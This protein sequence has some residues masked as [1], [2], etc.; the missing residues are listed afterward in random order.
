MR[1][2]RDLIAGRRTVTGR[3]VWWGVFGFFAAVFAANG[4]M[5]WLA[6]STFSGVETEDAYQ[7]GR[8]FNRAIEATRQQRALGWQVSITQEPLATSTQRRITV[9]YRNKTGEQ[10]G[11]LDV[12]GTFWSPT[13]ADADRTAKLA[14]VGAGVYGANFALPRPG[15]WELR[16]EARDRHGR[17]VTTR[18]EVYIAP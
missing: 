17:T 1:G 16:L 13:H 4:V 3:D 10:L 9:T 6:V 5:A 14:R 12:T 15:R 18:R 7:K 8:E 11:G 2:L